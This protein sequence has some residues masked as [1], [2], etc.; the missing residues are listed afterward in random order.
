MGLEGKVHSS[1]ALVCESVNYSSDVT[2]VS[3]RLRELEVQLSRSTTEMHESIKRSSATT[4][5]S[6]VSARLRELEVQLSRNITEMHESIKHSSAT[7]EDSVSARFD[8]LMVQISAN[9]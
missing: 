1:N 7:T 5:D 3:A 2:E 4:D 6:E 8:E 9:A